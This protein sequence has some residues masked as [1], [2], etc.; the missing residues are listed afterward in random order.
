MEGADGT[1][2]VLTVPRMFPTP[3][4]HLPVGW[5]CMH[6]RAGRAAWDGR[7]PAAGALSLPV[8]GVP[9]QIPALHKLTAA[10]PP[11]HPPWEVL[12]RQGWITQHT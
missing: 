5:P 8:P 7:P 12:G 1:A 11:P 9:Q 6:G 3:A 2:D 4:P 10:R